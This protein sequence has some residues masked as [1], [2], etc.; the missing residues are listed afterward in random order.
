MNTNLKPIPGFPDYSITQDGRVWS[1]DRKSKSG[2]S[3]KGKWLKL[4]VNSDGYF[5]V[6]LSL[7]EKSKVY[8]IHTLMLTTYVGPRLGDQ[9]CRHLNGNPLDNRLTNLTWGTQKENMADSVKHK[10]RYRAQ[11]TLHPLH[12]LD[13][14]DVQFIR[15]W[16]KSGYKQREIVEAFGVTSQTVSMIKTG[17]R[18]GWLN[19]L[20]GS[21]YVSV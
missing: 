15:A 5:C 18:W 21:P 12:K 19:N 6:G 14:M 4:T 13:E 1:R 17:N 9:V 7:Q 10:T 2:T 8:T 20:D 16:C 3:I 11:G